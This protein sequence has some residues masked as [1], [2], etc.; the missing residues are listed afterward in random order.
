M[1]NITWLGVH[2]NSKEENWLSIV[3][4]AS[5]I[6]DVNYGFTL[7]SFLLCLFCRS[8]GLKSPLFLSLET[9]YMISSVFRSLEKKKCA[10]WGRSVHVTQFHYMCGIGWYAL[11]LFGDFRMCGTFLLHV[12]IWSVC[13]E[14]FL[15]HLFCNF[16]YLKLGWPI[17]HENTHY[18]AK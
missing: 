17:T 2:L 6:V 9:L 8:L 13:L 14:S 12:R 15:S 4:V 18:E 1:P 5:S 7:E 11:G 16:S 10:S 3:E